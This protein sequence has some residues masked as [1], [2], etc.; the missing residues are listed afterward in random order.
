PV[1]VEVG[2][3]DEVPAAVQV[4]GQDALGLRDAGPGARRVLAEVHRAEGE[5]AHP[6]AGT[7]KGD[8]AVGW[9]CFFLR[10]SEGCQI[11]PYYRSALT[12][13]GVVRSS[14]LIA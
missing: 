10:V 9:H 5:R 1:R 4:G 8:V 7:A 12:C 6:Q 3:V 13:G 2:R 11:A 14:R